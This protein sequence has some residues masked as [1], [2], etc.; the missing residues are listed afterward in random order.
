[1][2][3]SR[4]R[5]LIAMPLDRPGFFGP[6]HAFQ[7]GVHV[8]ASPCLD[9]FFR[10]ITA[11]VGRVVAG[12]GVNPGDPNLGPSPLLPPGSRLWRQV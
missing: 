5:A 8:L 12:A 2:A 7:D 9:P 1:M 10:R 3:V 6:S 11:L 4:D